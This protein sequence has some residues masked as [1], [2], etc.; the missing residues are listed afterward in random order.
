MDGWH[1][2]YTI[3]ADGTGKEKQ[4]T[5][6]ERNNRAIE[7]NSD[8]SKMLYL[9]GRDQLRV[10]DVKT[11]KSETI[12]TDEFWAIENSQPHFSP[13]DKW[14]AYTVYRNFEQDVFVINLETKKTYDITNTGIIRS[15]PG[16]V[17]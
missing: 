14:I 7:M 2:L 13:D 15:R 3:K 12:L 5:S 11:L 1:N 10:L 17:T 9:S 16:L 4:I 6:D 8:K